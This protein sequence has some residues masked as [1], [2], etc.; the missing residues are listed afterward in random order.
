MQKIKRSEAENRPEFQ[1]AKL[2]L[3]ERVAKIAN[4]YSRSEELSI[5]EK[6]NLHFQM[7][8]DISRMYLI[9][10]ES[11]SSDDLKNLSNQQNNLHFLNRLLALRQL[12]ETQLTGVMQ[13]TWGLP[14]DIVESD[15]FKSAMARSDGGGISKVVIMEYG[16]QIS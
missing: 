16:S 5:D 1:E 11:F 7:V 14:P 13:G 3:K 10:L 15:E 6:A 9:I 4:T 12:T 2:F 8:A